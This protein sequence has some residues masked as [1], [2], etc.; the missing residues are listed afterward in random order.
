MWGCQWKR[1]VIG[2][3]PNVEQTNPSTSVC[4]HTL[5]H[6]NAKKHIQKF[7]ITFLVSLL[8]YFPCQSKGLL[9]VC[10]HY[11]GTRNVSVIRSILNQL[12]GN[13][14]AINTAKLVKKTGR[15]GRDHSDIYREHYYGLRTNTCAQSWLRFWR[16]AE[17]FILCFLQ[18]FSTHIMILMRVSQSEVGDNLF[19]SSHMHTHVCLSKLT[20][21]TQAFMPA[22]RGKSLATGT[23]E[24]PE[25]PSASHLFL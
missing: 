14:S 3:L 24:V 25:G 21:L 13:I 1:L 18:I 10:S 20:L 12:L 11:I 5:A 4:V 2:A 15:A 8:K 22:L 7:N 23:N 6:M 17:R 16:R 19:P 9:P